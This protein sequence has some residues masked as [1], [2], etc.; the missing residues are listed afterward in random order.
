MADNSLN[1]IHCPNLETITLANPAKGATNRVL[2]VDLPKLKKVDLSSIT[3]LG[4]LDIF[5]DNTEVV[6]PKLNSFYDSNTKKVTKLT[7]G[8]EKVSVS[9]S[10]KTLESSAFKEFIKE[11]GQYCSDGKAYAEAEYGAVAWKNN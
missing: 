7:E 6:Y 3:T 9:V 10:Q 5:L 2:L 8:K 1:L 11:Y 4:K